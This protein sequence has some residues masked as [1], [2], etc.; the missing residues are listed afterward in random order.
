MGRREG[1]E[2]VAAVDLF[3]PV[4]DMGNSSVPFAVA[5]T[6]ALRLGRVPCEVEP[7][8][9]RL[10]GPDPVLPAIAGYEVATGVAH[11]RHAQLTDQ[12]KDIRAEAVLVG[13]WV[14]GLVDTCVHASAQMLDERAERAPTHGADAERRVDCKGCTDHAVSP[15]IERTSPRP[16][17]PDREVESRAGASGQ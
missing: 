2:R 4:G 11:R 3:T 10:H 15:F 8:R 13:L 1:C 16:V 5:L 12:G 9:P 17:R 6:Q 7:P 14:P